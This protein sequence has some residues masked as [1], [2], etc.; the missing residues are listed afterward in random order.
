MARRA[1]VSLSVNARKNSR[2]CASVRR[3]QGSFRSSAK[4]I[5]REKNRYASGASCVKRRSSSVFDSPC[6]YAS[7]N[8]RVPPG[9]RGSGGTFMT[10]SSGAHEHAELGADFAEA[11]ERKLELVARMGG[12]DD[13]AD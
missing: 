13:R 8:R 2:A 6:V 12:R 9:V 11:I 1:G 7:R 3:C 10:E 4:S 5:V